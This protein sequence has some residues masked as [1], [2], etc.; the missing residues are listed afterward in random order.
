MKAAGR[1]ASYRNR[2]PRQDLNSR[3]SEEIVCKLFSINFEVGGRVRENLRQG[4]DA[5]FAVRWDS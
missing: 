2:T 5:E 1:E 4:S 3:L